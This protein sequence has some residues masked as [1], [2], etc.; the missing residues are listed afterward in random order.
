MTDLYRV[1]VTEL[2]QFS[3]RRGDLPTGLQVSSG[4]TASE[5]QKA[6]RKLQKRR[7]KGVETEVAVSQ[8]L[9]GIQI[10]GRIDVV[11]PDQ[12][13]PIIE[14]IKSTHVSVDKLDHG[15]QQLHW[16]Q[17]KV[18]G[19]C[20]AMQYDLEQVAIQ[21][22][23]YNTLE[24]TEHSEQQI[25]SRAELATFVEQVV[26]RY[27]D[28]MR[29]L[30]AHREKARH[31]ARELRFPYGEFRPGQRRMAESVYRVIRDGG[32]LLAEAPT[33][34]GKTMSVLFP[35]VKAI[36][37]N[38]ID[39]I[40][41]LTAKRTTRELAQI[42]IQKMVDQ[43]LVLT[44]VI[45][46]AKKNTCFCLREDKSTEPV[47][48]QLGDPAPSSDESACA[49]CKGFFDRLPE[50]RKALLK[51][52]HLTQDVIERYGQ[53]FQLCPFELA[54]QM[55]HWVDIAVCDYSYVYDPL[56]RLAYF[57]ESRER[58]VALV[59]ESHNLP[60]R[61]RSMYSGALSSRLPAAATGFS[62]KDLLG[63][64]FQALARVL[65]RSRFDEDASEVVLAEPDNTVYNACQRVTEVISEFSEQGGRLTPEGLEWLKTLY[66]YLKIHELFA[67]SHRTI[68]TRQDR[69]TEI[70][71]FCCDA[72]RWLQVL[73]GKIHAKVFFSATLS[74]PA[75]FSHRLGA[76]SDDTPPHWPKWLALDATF[77]AENQGV[78]VL[79][80]IDLRWHARV[81]FESRIV[82]LIDILRTSKAGHY[83]VFFPSYGFMNQIHALW[84]QYRPDVPVVVQTPDS[85]DTEREAF[86]AHFSEGHPPTLGFAII[87]GV[88]AEGVDFEGDRLSGAMILGVG[89]PQFNLRQSLLKAEFEQ[90]GLPGFEYA[91]RYPAMTRVLQTAGRVIRS[92]TD[93]GAV[94]LVDSRFNH[95]EY[96]TLF[97]NHWQP[98][99]CAQESA[100]ANA[101][102]AFWRG[103]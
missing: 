58:M 6:H 31:T 12:L 86:L 75:F 55:L 60:D 85:K 11:Y 68:W 42:A 20:Y 98:E 34:T 82:Q 13:P 71:L 24:D 4:P 102:A 18:Y 9:P 2:V 95:A 7:P 52:G 45:L 83:L 41:Y 94:V 91:Y 56:V 35:A 40:L 19:Y 27:L 49:Y 10:S 66:R 96:R 51:A 44:Y 48:F 87:G 65:K 101:L 76:M 74:P 67:S 70:E 17:A 16:S 93:R 92:E 1:S 90:Q 81:R 53:D 77:P 79:P 39:K 14:E 37:A 62:R 78:F 23:W 21:V 15:Q 64:R 36:G 80:F 57:D 89:L 72:T 97:P 103:S 61:A 73:N 26:R 63:R 46:Q 38:K 32:N 84:Q 25:M 100:F 88:F 28:W 30:D 99:L 69:H 50:A 3:C 47:P 8:T 33:G 59:D 43:G 54:L 22:V 29:L 5:G